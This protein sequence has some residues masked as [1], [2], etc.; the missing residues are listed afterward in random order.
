MQQIQQTLQKL[1]EIAGLNEPAVDSDLEGRRLTVFINEGQWLHDWLPRLVGDLGHIARTIGRKVGV[2][3]MVYTDVN[4]Y[5]KD[6]ERLIVELAKAAA[7]KVLLTKNDV[8]LPAMN[9]Y[10]RRLVHTE[11]AIRPDVKT[12]SVG[13]KKERC[14]VVKPLL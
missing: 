1:L 5:R 3:G 9:A 4:N 7:R 12:E 2:D 13:E 8:T 11:L 10:E 14:V 6:R